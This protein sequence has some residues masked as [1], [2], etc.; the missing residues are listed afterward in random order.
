MIARL[1]RGYN[2]VIKHGYSDLKVIVYARS[3]GKGVL[4]GS[5][6]AVAPPAPSAIDTDTAPIRHHGARTR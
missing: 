6:Y 4:V 2:Y 1:L 5:N 3:N